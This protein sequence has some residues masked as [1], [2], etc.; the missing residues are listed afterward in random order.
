MSAKRY[1]AVLV[2]ALTA[3]LVGGLISSQFATEF[4]TSLLPGGYQSTLVVKDMPEPWKEAVIAEEFLLVDERGKIL[5][6]MGSGASEPL[7]MEISLEL[8]DKDNKTRIRLGI[9]YVTGEPKF[10]LLDKQGGQIVSP[11]L[12]QDSPRGPVLTKHE[13]DTT[14]VSPTP[15]SSRSAS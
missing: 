6:R 1:G 5:A 8:F 13:G 9:M 12:P 15:F 4:L 2:L 10:Q 7:G 11:Y 14:I 3:G